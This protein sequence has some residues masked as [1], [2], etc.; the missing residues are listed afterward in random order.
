MLRF[1]RLFLA[2]FASQ[3]LILMLG[4]FFLGAMLAG[5][6]WYARRR[7]RVR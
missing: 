6:G 4:F 7:W 3:L 1:L 2:L 5:A